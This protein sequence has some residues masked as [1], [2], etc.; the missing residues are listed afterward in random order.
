[1]NM[2]SVDKD[3]LFRNA[4]PGFVFIMVVL[5][6]IIINKDFEFFKETAQILLS[7][8]AAFPIGFIIQS[9]HRFAHAVFGEQRDMRD[10]EHRLLNQNL[11]R[12]NIRNI[13]ES[14][15]SA[16]ILAFSLDQKQNAHFRTRI[17]FHNSYWLALGASSIAIIFALVFVYYFYFDPSQNPSKNKILSM[18]WSIIAIIICLHRVNIRR[19]YQTARA[20]F[21]RTG[22]IM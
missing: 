1:M 7:I 21:I 5:S 18:I 10:E 12:L 20:V 8:I 2:D 11:T 15:I 16:Q 19:E 3:D 9:L 6:F 22:T 4:I 14:D 13:I 17:N